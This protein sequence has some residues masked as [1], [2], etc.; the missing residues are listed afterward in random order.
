MRVVI[1][2]DIAD[3]RILIL[4]QLSQFPVV[5]RKYVRTHQVEGGG[6]SMGMKEAACSG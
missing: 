3:W 2:H 6:Q 4:R 1:V 5:I